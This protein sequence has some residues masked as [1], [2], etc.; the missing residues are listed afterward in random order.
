VTDFGTGFVVYEIEIM[1]S[2]DSGRSKHT[3]VEEQGAWL[4]S[5]IKQAPTSV[6][7]VGAA[8][9]HILYWDQHALTG[10]PGR[11]E[12]IG[13]Y[14]RPTTR[15]S[16]PIGGISCVT[17]WRDGLI[18][19][20]CSRSTNGRVVSGRA[21]TF[22]SRCTPCSSTRTMRAES[23]RK[24]PSQAGCGGH[25][26]LGRLSRPHWLVASRASVEARR[27][28]LTCWPGWCREP[29]FVGVSRAVHQ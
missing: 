20:S 29:L 21:V 6:E 24:T 10:T 26:R 19:R 25:D 17:T 27:D 5:P 4:A 11:E 13:G 3:D 7:L 22:L 14:I 16:Q 2:S 23:S 9:A 1:L 8:F 28:T 18:R 15:S 12:E